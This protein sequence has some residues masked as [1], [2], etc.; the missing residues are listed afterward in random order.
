VKVAIDYTTAVWPGAGINRYTASLVAALAKLDRQNEYTLFYGGS[1][2]VPKDSEHWEGMQDILI[3]HP[4]FTQV[5]TPL[6]LKMTLRWQRFAPRFWPLERFTGPVDLLHAPDFVAPASRAPQV[7]TVHDLSFLT[8]PECAEEG[9]RKYLTA[10]M[11]RSVQRAD[12]II[13]VSQ[14]T[15]SDLIRL[16]NVAEEKITVIYEGVDSRFHPTSLLKAQRERV[17]LPDTPYILALSRLEPR[18]NFVRLIAAFGQLVAEGYPHALVFGGRRG[19]K[20]EPII[21]AA[22]ALNAKHGQRVYFLDHVNERDLPSVYAGAAACAYPSLYEGFGLPPLEA[23]ACGT[24]VL[25]SNVSSLPE[26]LGDAALLVAPEDVDAIA[27]GLRQLLDDEGLRAS[28]REKGLA[29]AQQLSWQQSA[30]AVLTLYQRYDRQATAPSDNV[31]VLA[32]R[33]GQQFFARE[34][35][36][37]YGRTRSYQPA[38]CQTSR[39][40]Q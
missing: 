8:V 33:P 10:T 35:K 24:P 40:N 36:P 19:W 18:K 3:S 31:L 14:S 13:A 39:P 27:N 15:K 34:V 4:N 30:Q 23:L 20:Y 29:R 16:L 32:S 37:A 26:V 7:I 6:S 12:H 38:P 17:G 25:A 11:P 5:P 9:L 28:L 2:E 1:R 21:A 22:A